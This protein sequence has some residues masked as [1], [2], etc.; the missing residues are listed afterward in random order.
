LYATPNI[1]IIIIIIIITTITITITII[2]QG[3]RMPLTVCF[4]S[5][6]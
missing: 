6:V 5:E 4:G 1:I 2:L 3:L